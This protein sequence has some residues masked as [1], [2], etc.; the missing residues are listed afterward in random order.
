MIKKYGDY[1]IDKKLGLFLQNITAA[2]W[3]IG[4]SGTD[5]PI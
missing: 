5:L 1:F 2:K 4:E 3:N